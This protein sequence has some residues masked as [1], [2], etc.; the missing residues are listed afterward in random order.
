M[1]LI[2]DAS[3]MLLVPQLTQSNRAADVLK[4]HSDMALAIWGHEKAI[5]FALGR[6]MWLLMFAWSPRLVCLKC[7]EFACHEIW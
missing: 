6:W 2:T 3:I 7:R 5:C 1:I 4:S